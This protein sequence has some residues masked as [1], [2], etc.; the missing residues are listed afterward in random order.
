M[1]L[2]MRI[3][4]FLRRR[5]EEDQFGMCGTIRCKL[6]RGTSISVCGN[7]VQRKTEGQLLGGS[8]TQTQEHLDFVEI[9]RV[10]S[11]EYEWGAR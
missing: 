1:C 11:D 10:P 4:A 2:K 9:Y 7:C 6:D 8:R 5:S 3:K